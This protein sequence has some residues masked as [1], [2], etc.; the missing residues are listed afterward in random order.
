MHVG[1]TDF[2]FGVVVFP[3]GLHCAAHFRGRAEGE[4]AQFFQRGYSFWG[5]R[6]FTI[7]PMTGL[8]PRWF[9]YE[10]CGSGLHGM[11]NLQPFPSK[12]KVNVKYY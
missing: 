3:D 8:F 9:L 7:R 11:N 5:H 1:S 10:H 2:A 6:K 12:I 4:R